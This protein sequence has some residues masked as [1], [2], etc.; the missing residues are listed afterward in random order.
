MGLGNG[1]PKSGNQGSNFNF[2]L[3]NL[4]LLGRLAAALPLPPGS[5]ATEA[6]LISVLN[7]IVASDQDI[8]ILLVRDTGNG[9]IVLQQI[10]DYQTGVPV[11]TYKDVNGN[12]VVPV[13][14]LE[15][16]DPSA[17]LNLILT[18]MTALNAKVIVDDDDNAI[19][20]GQ[21][22]PLSIVELYGAWDG[23]WQR[24]NTDGNGNLSVAVDSSVLP[25]GAATEVTLAALN[26]KFNTLG[27]KVSAASTPVVLSTEQEAVIAGIT[28]AIT[29][30]GTGA[31]STE[32][33]LLLTNALLTG[34]DAV[35]D[36]ILTDT[37]AIAVDTAAMVVDLAAIEALLTLIELDTGNILTDTNAMVVDLAAIEVLLTTMDA[38]LD[39]IKLDTADIKTATEA[40][41]TKLTAVVRTPGMLRVIAAGAASVTAGKRSVSVYN[42]GNATATWLGQTLLKGERLSWNAG[43]EEDTLG[44]FAYNADTSSLLITWTV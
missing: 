43:A 22:L 41:N 9:D 24:V 20:E 21:T 2:E 26:A 12:V 19:A 10:T 4:Q 17:V 37:T 3:R 27:Q 7:A 28:A 16:L 31:L 1:N 18:Q 30:L 44:A 14:P 33:T 38:V 35:L 6:T 42:Y 29:A 40:I 32:A 13:G 25:T 8:E 36:N 5:L 11:V 15:Y 23:A 34:I 39:T